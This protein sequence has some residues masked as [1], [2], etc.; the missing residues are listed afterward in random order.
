[1]IRKQKEDIIANQKHWF[2]SIEIEPDLVTPGLHSLPIMK[3]NLKRLELPD[4][5]SGMK[6]LDIGACDG[7]YSF[8]AEKRGAERVV[9]YEIDPQDHGIAQ[10]IR[11]LDSKVELI[12]G[13]VY[14]LT[15]TLFGTFDIVLFL[16]VFYHLRYP[17]LAL[18]KIFPICDL[19]MVLSTYHLPDRFLRE[20]GTRSP[21]EKDIIEE[22][23]VFQFCR[24]D[25]MAK[26]DFSNW[27]APNRE[28]VEAALKSSGFDPRYM[29][30]WGDRILFKAYKEQGLPEWERLCSPG[31][32]RYFSKCDG[33][34]DE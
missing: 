13:D 1:M 31:G 22:I 8:E 10:A 2:H 4:D 30:S 18:D 33:G 20:D 7:F 15:P 28:G 11:M 21:D 25:E 26:N 6:V 27:F 34:K 19:Y 14:D 23:P 12:Q 32:K 29:A 16:G 24:F 5:M 9:A 3:E 17:L